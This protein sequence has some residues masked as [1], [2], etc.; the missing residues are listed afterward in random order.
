MAALYY[1]FSKV[2]KTQITFWDSQSKK[3]LTLEADAFY[4]R[5]WDNYMLDCYFCI[6]LSHTRANYP[7]MNDSILWDRRW[8]MNATVWKIQKFCKNFVKST[9]SRNIFQMMRPRTRVIFWFFHIVHVWQVALSVSKISYLTIQI[10][11]WPWT[12]FSFH[13]LLQRFFVNVRRVVI[14]Q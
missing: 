7:I 1:S 13:K 11:I 9:F 8:K 12:L 10:S 4:Y 6:F 5:F 14:N 2:G 3:Q